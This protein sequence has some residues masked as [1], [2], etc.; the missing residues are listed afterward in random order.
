MRAGFYNCRGGPGPAKSVS[1][2]PKWAPWVQQHFL[3][4]Q[5]PHP[6]FNIPLDL[7]QWPLSPGVGPELS[8]V[9]QGGPGD[10]P[11]DGPT[12]GD[13]SPLHSCRP[14][15]FPPTGPAGSLGEPRAAP[16]HSWAG[17]PWTPAASPG[18]WA[19]Q[20]ARAHWVQSLGNCS[21]TACRL[22]SSPHELTGDTQH[23]SPTALQPAPPLFC[24][25]SRTEDRDR[26]RGST[27]CCRSV[28]EE[29]TGASSHQSDDK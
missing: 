20:R 18:P 7:F 11:A 19:A 26:S 14:K 5:V 28:G 21:G 25:G 16:E 15:H 24:P 27:G 2:C 8:P 6:L 9:S 29:R 1:P 3:L 10:I 22:M 12:L 23:L 17:S 13:R 4:L